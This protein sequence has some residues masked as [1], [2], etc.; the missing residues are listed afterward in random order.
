MPREPLGKWQEMLFCASMFRTKC[1]C[2]CPFLFQA[3]VAA[4]L[5]V[6]LNE[7][8]SSETRV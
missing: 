2:S 5:V 1:V 7:L 3:Q 6:F 8:L 4:K